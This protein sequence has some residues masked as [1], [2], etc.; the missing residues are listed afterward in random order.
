MTQEK[1][2]SV[3]F[4]PL[5]TWRDNRCE[6]GKIPRFSASLPT[7]RDNRPSF[8]YAV[9]GYYPLPMLRDYRFGR[10]QPTM[11]ETYPPY[12]EG[13]AQDIL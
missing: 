9:S 5:S 8:E 4:N 2:A 1:M 3:L 10:Y 7:R 11:V 12:A 13:E 6:Q